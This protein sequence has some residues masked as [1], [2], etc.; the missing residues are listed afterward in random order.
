MVSSVALKPM[1]IIADK[2]AG[3]G[4]RLNSVRSVMEANAQ[5]MLAALPRHITPERMTRVA[6][7]SITRN[8]KLLDCTPT[9][10]FRAITEAATL[11]L[12]PDGVL[13]QAYL[14]PFKDEVVLVPGYKGLIDLARRS[15]NISTLFARSVRE[16]DFFDYREGDDP[17]LDHKPSDDPDRENKPITHVYAVCVLRDGGVQRNVWSRAKV[18]KHK[19]RFSQGW[20]R[21]ERGKKDSPWH[22]D[23]EAMARKTVIREMVNRGEIPV[24]VEVQRLAAREELYENAQAGPAP[25]QSIQVSDLAAMLNAPPTTRRI[26]DD[27]SQD[28]EAAKDAPVTD[29]AS[30][31]GP[32]TDGLSEPEVPKSLADYARAVRSAKTVKQVDVLE[33]KWITGEDCPLSS[34]EFEAG[35][36]FAEWK[37]SQI[38]G[39][40]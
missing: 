12:E 38:G 36:A 7:N 32:A 8:P 27:T 17:K 13:G 21:A 3:F 4:A 26:E 35:K 31:D 33:A 10:L 23:W 11:G 30:Q 15:A 22:T 14:I 2:N 1:E 20:K 19:E 5:Q 40:A 25:G 9:S 37:R 24:S 34:E 16:G 18:D 39:A 28:P 6:L 29:D